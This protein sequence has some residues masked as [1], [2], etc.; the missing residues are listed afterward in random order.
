[1]N[2][3]LSK[4][5]IATCFAAAY[6]LTLE[7]EA[8]LEAELESDPWT[9]IGSAHVEV[10]EALDGVIDGVCYRDIKSAGQARFPSECPEGTQKNLLLP[11]C[12]EKCGSG[13]MEWG[14]DCLKKCKRGYHFD[15]FS[16]KCRKWFRTYRPEKRARNFTALQCDEDEV[17]DLANLCYDE[18]DEG[19]DLFWGLQIS[20]CPDDLP[21]ECGVMCTTDEAECTENLQD[22]GMSAAQF[23][24]SLA[25]QNHYNA[26][27]FGAQTV[28]A[29]AIALC[30]PDAY[31]D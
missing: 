7:A 4:I 25:T 31:L 29:F 28:D 24:L 21:Y 16:Q 9:A 30:N 12:E 8:E 19:Y 11:H 23:L 17:Q 3:Q 20:E 26:V 6:G 22:Q 15:I 14:F 18:P 1:M 2:K 27:V 10:Q 5:M 13:W